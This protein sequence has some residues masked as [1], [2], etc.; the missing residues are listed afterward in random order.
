MFESPP[1]SN[2]L[3]VSSR[4]RKWGLYVT[5]AGHD[6]AE[7]GSP[8]PPKTHPEGYHFCW[9]KGRILEEFALVFIPRGKGRFE[10]VHGGKHAISAGVCFFLFPGE[11]HRYRPEEK[12]GWEE[13]WITFGGMIP[14]QWLKEGFLRLE[15]PIAS[16]TAE[17][18]LTSTFEEVFRLLKRDRPSPAFTLA[19]LCHL[20]VGRVLGTHFEEGEPGEGELRLHA[21]ADFL[22]RHAAEDVDLEGLAR[23]QNFS[24][25]GFRRAFRTHFGVPPRRY[26][27]MARLKLA[28]EM[29]LQ[30]DLPLKAIAV[31][32]NYGTEFYFM[33]A[34]KKGVGQ[35]PT[36]WRTSRPSSV[37]IP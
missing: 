25:S 10:S 6:V 31:S 12:E 18:A 7:P 35:T 23:R 8:Y 14:E 22:T 11:W 33:Q 9:E 29:L 37:D 26:H 21:A 3:P 15:N 24:Y 4:D 20:L 34:F 19:G 17:L 13:Y 16:V 2:Y 5:G 36:Q 27:Q 30:T 32:L 28:K 1:F